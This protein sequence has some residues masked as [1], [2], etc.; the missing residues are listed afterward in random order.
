MTKRINSTVS[1]E[2]YEFAQAMDKGN[3]SYVV[4][5]GLRA[6]QRCH[7]LLGDDWLNEI[8]L[9]AITLHQVKRAFGDNWRERLEQWTPN[10]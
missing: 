5:Q 6:L 9:A 7:Y 2:L 3:L 10:D 1:D 8:E 4:R